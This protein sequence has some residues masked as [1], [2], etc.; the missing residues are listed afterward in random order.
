MKKKQSLS[1]R[2]V[3]ATKKVKWSAVY[4]KIPREVVKVFFSSSENDR[5]LAHVMFYLFSKAYYAN[6]F[7]KQGTRMYPCMRGEYVGTTVDIAE[8]CHFSINKATRCLQEL[9][10]EGKI[11]VQRLARGTRVQI[12]G[13]DEFMKGEE[14]EVVKRAKPIILPLPQKALPQTTQ[15]MLPPPPTDERNY[16]KDVIAKR[17]LDEQEQKDKNA[18]QGGVV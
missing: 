13:F 8:S 6:G 1:R 17:L 10:A 2:G 16:Y 11:V 15:P 7:V 5:A 18:T 14:L 3:A 9:Q 4:V 12:V